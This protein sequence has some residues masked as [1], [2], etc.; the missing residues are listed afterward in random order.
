M[1]KDELI[2]LLEEEI[3]R[4][5]SQKE[6]AWTHGVS[7]QHLSDVLNGHRELSCK[8]L[9]ALGYRRVVLYERAA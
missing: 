3:R 5:G 9:D 8:I 7:Q 2:A 6:W 4:S 1:T